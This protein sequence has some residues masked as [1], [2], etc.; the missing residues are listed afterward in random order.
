MSK[1][2]NDAQT[3]AVVEENLDLDQLIAKSKVRLRN[4]KII[5]SGVVT[6]TVICFIAR[7]IVWGGEING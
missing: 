6:L 5:C 1:L 7:L 3:I 4:S 2:E